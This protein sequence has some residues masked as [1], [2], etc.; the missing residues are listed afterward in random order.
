MAV[1]GENGLGFDVVQVSL[2]LFLGDAALDDPRHFVKDGILDQLSAFP[3]CRLAVKI[4]KPRV[5]G[6]IGVVGASA[7]RDGVLADEALIEAAGFAPAEDRF[8]HDEGRA[9]LALPVGHVV[10]H[11]DVRKLGFFFKGDSPG[12]ALGGL[13]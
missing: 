1:H 5:E 8:E 3:R 13:G 4:K 10:G 6:Y 2:K 7:Q 12:G 11:G 9:V